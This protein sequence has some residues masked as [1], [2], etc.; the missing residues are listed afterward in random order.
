V[1]SSFAES[2][3]A[4]KLRLNALPS[5]IESLTLRIVKPL[6]DAAA[7]NLG[8]GRAPQFFLR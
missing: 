2:L 1:I 7:W 4:C 3:V 5:A 6:N 8:R